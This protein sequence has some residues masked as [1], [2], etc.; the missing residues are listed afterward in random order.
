MAASRRPL[1]APIRA[2][3]HRLELAGHARA[4]QT[5]LYIHLYPVPHRNMLDNWP[6]RPSL[7]TIDS[8]GRL[9]LLSVDCF[10]SGDAHQGAAAASFE[11]S[12]V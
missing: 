12:R 10:T 8:A 9:F 1:A 7:T 5:V 4:I 3:R 2:G 6:R 11:V